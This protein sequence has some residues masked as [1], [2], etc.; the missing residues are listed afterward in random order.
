M[1]QAQSTSRTVVLGCLLALAAGWAVPAGAQVVEPDEWF[2]RLAPYLWAVSLDAT[3]TVGTEM[4]DVSVP[5]DVSFGDIFDLVDI[6]FSAHFEVGK[7]RWT[8]VADVSYV[9]LGT[10][11]EVGGDAPPGTEAGYEFVMAAGELWASYRVNPLSDNWAFEFLGGIRYTRQDMDISITVGDPGFGG[12]FDENWVDPIV[13]ARYVT[14]FGRDKFFFNARGD[15]GGFGVGADFTWNMIGGLGWR[16]SRLIDIALQYKYLD[17]D[18]KN[19]ESG[20]TDYFAFDG[21]EQ[22][23]LLGVNFNF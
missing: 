6:A 9:K 7:N 11:V 17:V 3:N 10:G 8:G 18:Y 22:G 5:V 14:L 12:G 16:V 4:G 13:G 23:V 21:N 2:L 20:T 15:I 1:R 19:G